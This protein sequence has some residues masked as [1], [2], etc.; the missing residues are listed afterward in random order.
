[1]TAAHAAIHARLD[2]GR[3]AIQ[4]SFD[5]AALAGR[6]RQRLYLAPAGSGPVS[7]E[8]LFRQDETV[9]DLIPQ[10]CGDSAVVIDHRVLAPGRSVLNLK[11]FNEFCV[12]IAREDARVV[13]RYPAKAPLTYLLDDVLQAAVQ[14]F[15]EEAGGFILHGA[16]LVKDGVAFA[17]MGSSGSGKSTTAFNLVR[18]GYHCYA[19]DAIIVT[20]EGAELLA[21]PFSREMSIRPLSQQLMA[22]QGLSF[23]GYRQEGKKYYFQQPD[24]PANAGVPLC[25]ACLIE[26]GGE[27]A[28]RA[29]R[30]ERDN[31]LDRLRRDQRYFS[32][33]NREHHDR[34]A[35][36][37]AERVPQALS[38]RLGHDLEAQAAFFDA[39]VD[40]EAATVPVAT[41]TEDSNGRAAKL[42]LIR[43]AWRSPGAEP[44]ADLV[45]MLGD[46]DLMIF[47]NALSFFQNYPLAQLAPGRAASTGDASPRSDDVC[48]WLR[49]PEWREG[50]RR[51]I[52]TT[53]H[54][55]YDQY[56]AGW[57]K[58]A[59]ILYAFLPSLV[60]RDSA[61][62]HALEKAW[63]RYRQGARTI[64]DASAALVMLTDR[65]AQSADVLTTNTG[66]RCV[67]LS[68]QN[69]DTWGEAF[70]RLANGAARQ[71]SLVPVFA[72]PQANLDVVV[73]CVRSARSLGFEA[74]LAPC[75]P[76]CW[77]S[78]S[79]ATFLLE[80]GALGDSA[81]A[82]SM[83]TVLGLVNADWI[84]AAC[85]ATGACQL[86]GLGLCNRGYFRQRHGN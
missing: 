31:F 62:R 74:R 67:Y 86:S 13:V 21:W 10:T 61:A 65:D 24:L 39:L 26:V 2:F 18:A 71:F 41:E 84:E 75:V 8:I 49:A 11:V 48:S 25:F 7:G 43:R 47:K 14:P 23:S 32:F 64:E 50:C 33:V 69:P 19:D 37:V 76:I 77:F 83:A 58:S 20:R 45:P 81:D 79:Q 3:H 16:C 54:E 55:A 42:E 72:T 4:L 29:L 44:L 28:T 12:S 52:Q 22:S 56:A 27:A 9:V 53:C 36:V 51:L 63:V 60:A 6:A 73:E 5:N 85:A 35:D 1:V 34:Y 59:P 68:V 17:L 66:R 78:E 30:L 82:F 57:F 70:N 80:Q 40:P 15:L 38:I 46:S